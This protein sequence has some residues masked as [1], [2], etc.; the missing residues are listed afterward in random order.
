MRDIIRNLGEWGRREKRK[1]GG[2]YGCRTRAFGEFLGLFK[3]CRIKTGI[4]VGSHPTAVPRGNA[5]NQGFQE[6]LSYYLR[7]YVK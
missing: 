2:S 7:V 5:Q 6:I 4:P 1:L 3:S